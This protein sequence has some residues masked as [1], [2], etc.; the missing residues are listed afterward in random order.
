[1]KIAVGADHKGFGLKRDIKGYLEAQGHEVIDLGT[2]SETSVDYPDFGAKTAQAVADGTADLGLTFCW[3]G[4]G[5]AIA[6]NKLKGIRS[7]VALNTDMAQLAKEHNNVNVLA[8]ASKYVE[9]E[10]AK[11]IV[12]T[13]LAA[14]FEGGRHAR[15]VEKI[16][17]L[18]RK[19]HVGSLT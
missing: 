11:A 19:N 14:E 2:D 18:E 12:A 10:Q 16:A 6:A 1:M 4:T 15:R 5:M 8:I 3:T 13:W 17:A 7:A 9:P